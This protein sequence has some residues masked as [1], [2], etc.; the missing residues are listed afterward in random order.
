MAI[1]VFCLAVDGK[2]LDAA[3][4]EALR[5]ALCRKFTPVFLTPAVNPL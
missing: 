3:R 2:K 4:L 5:T 1:E